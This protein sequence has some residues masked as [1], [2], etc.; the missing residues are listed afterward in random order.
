MLGGKK[1]QKDH[2][3]GQGWGVEAEGMGQFPE[4]GVVGMSNPKQSC[5]GIASLVGPPLPQGLF[6]GH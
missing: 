6:R 5:L 4:R 1:S 3:P 2:R